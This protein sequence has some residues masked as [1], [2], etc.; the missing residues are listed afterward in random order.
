MVT[1]R[2]PSKPVAAK[3]AASKA[4]PTRRG[5]G[6]EQELPPKM[7]QHL[8]EL[9]RAFAQVLDD[10]VSRYPNAKVSFSIDAVITLGGGPPVNADGDE[11]SGPLTIS[12]LAPNSD[13]WVFL[14]HPNNTNAPQIALAGQAEEHHKLSGGVR[15]FDVTAK[16][17]RSLSVVSSKD[18]GRN[19]LSQSPVELEG[20][21]ELVRGRQRATA[22]FNS[23][24]TLNLAN[25][26]VRVFRL[27]KA[28]AGYP[29]AS[30]T[31]TPLP[32]GGIAWTRLVL[33]NGAEDPAM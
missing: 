31:W 4:A 15:L 5:G 30:V 2:V 18:L 33:A 12:H 19:L 22:P 6:A 24:I 17:R 32:Q 3:K 21:K 7:G 9:E 8:L 14:A 28:V 27:K 16:I 13:R 11:I 26:S 1:K 10:L 23:V 20:K 29:Q 25:Y